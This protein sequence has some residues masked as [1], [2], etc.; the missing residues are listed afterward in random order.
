MKLD[1]R[2]WR[3]D[4][5]TPV[6]SKHARANRDPTYRGRDHPAQEKRGAEQH[7]SLA[8][9][10][11]A[12]PSRRY[13]SQVDDAVDE[14]YAVGM[15]GQAV[16]RRP[17]RGGKSQDKRLLGRSTWRHTPAPGDLDR[18]NPCRSGR[19][20]GFEFR[21]LSFLGDRLGGRLECPL[22]AI[23]LVSRANRLLVLGSS[24]K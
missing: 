22:T 3:S 5:G 2:L 15:I 7:C 6:R 24:A 23:L 20:S 12:A 17:E 13:C 14:I 1:T 16:E 11:I 10:N 21:V 9:A 19:L 4:Q 18:R 8:N